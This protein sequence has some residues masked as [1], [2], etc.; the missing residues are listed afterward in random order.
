M[1]RTF[2]NSV[3]LQLSNMENIRKRRNKGPLY[4]KPRAKK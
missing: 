3:K 2:F 1:A 4:V